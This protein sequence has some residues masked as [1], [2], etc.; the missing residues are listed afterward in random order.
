MLVDAG[1]GQRGRGI[2]SVG[3]LVTRTRTDALRAFRLG[4]RVRSDKIRI[5]GRFTWA[6]GFLATAILTILAY[7]ADRSARSDL[8]AFFGPRAFCLTEQ[9]KG[10]FAEM[11]PRAEGY[12]QL[13]IVY[14]MDTAPQQHMLFAVAI[15][16]ALR[17]S[18]WSREIIVQPAKQDLR[19]EPGIGVSG[20]GDPRST[21]VRDALIS[22]FKEAGYDA[23]V[24]NRRSDR[25]CDVKETL[26]NWTAERRDARC[27]MVEIW[28]GPSSS[29][30]RT[31][32]PKCK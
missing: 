22:A 28:A 13:A 27:T 26:T 21:K 20:T 19:Q 29:Q 30:E 25:F 12:P 15:A 18:N 32:A 1:L 14:F 8:E 2:G 5:F 31:D 3:F 16:D 23:H 4:L 9:L 24:S 10:R 6:V 11:G 7:Y 17:G